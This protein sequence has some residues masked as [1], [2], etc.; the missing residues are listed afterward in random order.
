MVTSLAPDYR[1]AFEVSHG[2]FRKI[3]QD[4]IARHGDPPWIGIRLAPGGRAGTLMAGASTCRHIGPVRP[5][6]SHERGCSVRVS[7]ALDGSVRISGRWTWAGRVGLAISLAGLVGF[8]ILDRLW[9]PPADVAGS[10]S[11]PTWLVASTWALLGLG[12]VGQAVSSLWDHWS[13]I[14]LT[15]H[16]AVVHN[17][18]SRVVAWSDVVNVEAGTLSNRVV[19][20]TSHGK[21][22]LR[23]PTGPRSAPQAAEMVTRWWLQHGGTPPSPP[24]R[25]L[26]NP[27][28]R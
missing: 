5:L 2:C 3:A 26:D 12:V 25:T 9:P 7:E 20:N 10:S 15:D 8:R 27:W 21:I 23:G 6:A 19:L 4:R 18:R 1:N 28:V 22:R 11:P 17:V 14:T 16:H 24:V 13:G